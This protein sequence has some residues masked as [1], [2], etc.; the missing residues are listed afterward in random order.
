MGA[1]VPFIIDFGAFPG[2]S[3]ASVTVTGLTGIATTSRVEAYIEPA[4]S[5]DHSADEHMVETLKLFADQSSIVANTSCVVKA[6]N[7][8]QLNEPLVPPKT[9]RFRAVGVGTQ[10][11]SSPAPSVGGMGTR[12]YGKWN[13]VLVGF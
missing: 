12:I 4:P 13:G 3:D 5:A 8:N 6:F 2:A 1:A 9:D 7:T 10:I 11:L